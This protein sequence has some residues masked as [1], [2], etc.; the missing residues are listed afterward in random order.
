MIYNTFVS[1]G[2]SFKFLILYSL[3]VSSQNLETIGSYPRLLFHGLS[4]VIHAFDRMLKQKNA[5]KKRIIFPTTGCRII[6]QLT[7]RSTRNY[8]L[9]QLTTR[10]LRRLSCGI[11]RQ[12]PR[13]YNFSNP[14]FSHF[15]SFSGISCIV[16]VDQHEEIYD[17][18]PKN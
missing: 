14:I 5:G 18:Q 16:I 2:S 7:R 4:H 3:K 9:T 6:G 12:R 8:Q 10:C 11:Q 17:I 1:E 13:I 15:L